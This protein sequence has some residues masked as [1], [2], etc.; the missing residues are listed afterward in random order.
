MEVSN[1]FN[2]Y[3]ISIKILMKD[4]CLGSLLIRLLCCR[5]SLNLKECYGNWLLDLFQFQDFGWMPSWN[6]FQFDQ[7]IICL[8]LSKETIAVWLIFSR[9]KVGY[10]TLKM[11]D[12]F[13]SFQKVFWKHLLPLNDSAVWGPTAHS[14]LFIDMDQSFSYQI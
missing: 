6:F 5:Q 4:R 14:Y 8:L 12:Q 7:T 1:S 9:L 2:G 11:D 10:S 3:L 13:I